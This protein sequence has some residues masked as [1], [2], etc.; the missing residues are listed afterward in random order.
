MHLNLDMV[1]ADAF[2][3]RNLLSDLVRRYEQ[4]GTPLP[5]IGYSY[6]RYL[7]EQAQALAN[8]KDEARAWWH[9]QLPSLPAA[10]ALPVHPDDDTE[11]TVTRRHH[12]LEQAAV[13]RL[14]EKARQ[15][16]LTPATV[17][18]TVFAEVIG[19]WSATDRFLLNL[20]VF[21]REPLHDDVD[22]LVGDFSSSVML[23]VDL[24]APMSFTERANALR[25]RL[26][27]ASSQAHYTGVE[28][29]RD[30]SKL[31]GE[32][33]IAPVVY[34]SALDLGELFSPDVRRCFGEPGWIISQGPQV[35][36]DAQVTEF[37]GGVLANWDARDS[38]FPA[39]M[40]DAMF[41]AY[42]GLIDR[43]LD[44]ESAWDEPVPPL[45][46]TAQ[47][48]ARDGVNS[49]TDTAEALV[50]PP[51]QRFF[52]IAAAEPDRTALLWGES[53]SMSYGELSTR[54]RGLARLLA[55][56]G[57]GPG[58]SV[59]ITLP[60]GRDQV[61]AVLAALATGATY[62][63]SGI[64]VPVA[65]REKVFG[66]AAAKF[67][68]TDHASAAEAGV[69][70]AVEPI[71]VSDATTA[72][73]I[74]AP[75]RVDPENVMY[76]IFTSGSTGDP[77]GVEV[78]HRAVANT[79]DAVNDHFA[80]TRD[81]RTIALSAVDFDL[82]AYDLFAFL[83]YGGSV[84]VPDEAQRRDAAAWAELI[85]RWDVTVVSCVP[86]L[87]D[88]LLIA[89]ADE[90]LGTALRL[91]MLG[92]DWVGVDLPARLRE[93]VPG[94]RFAGLGGMTEAAIHATVCEVDAVDPAWRAVPY[95]V[96]LAG[97]TCRVVDG[98]GRDCP[99]WVPGELW[100]GGA[101][102]A[103]GYR[104][105]PHRTAEK[106]V[107]HGGQRW[108]RT[109]DLVRY[110]PGAVLEFLG[111]TDHQ[112]KIRGHRIELGE[113][114]AA[115]TRHPQVSKAIATVV[116]NASRQLTAAVVAEPSTDAAALRSWLGEQLPGYLIPE[117]IAVVEAFPITYNGKID[118]K[119]I[120]EL[121]R[122]GSAEQRAAQPP[123][124]P[125]ETTLAQLWREVLGAEQVNRDDDFFTLG[126]D[127]LLATRLLRRLPESGLAGDLAALFTTP[128]LSGFAATLTSG[129]APHRTALAPDPD[130]RYDAF[131]LTDLQRGFWIGR[132]PAL[133]LGGV[134]S[135]FYLEFDGADIDL[136]RLEAALNRL[137]ERHDMLRA[138]ITED[139]T[140]RVLPEVPYYRIATVDA[141]HQPESTLHRLRHTLSHNLVDTARWPLFEVRA[142]RYVSGGSSRT[143][144]F[145]GLDSIVMDGRSIMVFYTE[146]DRLYRDLDAE[147][148]P[149][150]LA[151]RDYVLQ[152]RPD[153]QQVDA[154]Q[155]YWRQRVAELPP[156][157]R[158]PL[159]AQPAEIGTP[160]FHRLHHY[161]EPARW[162][163]IIDRCR[164]H[165]LTPSVVLLACYAEVLGA[166]SA[167]RELTVNLTLFDRRDVHD[168][169]G[170]VIGDF[171]SLLLIGHTAGEAEPF[172]DLARRL[173]EQQ[174]RGLAHR[175]T[176]GVWV[177]RELARQTGSAAA[178]L[179]VVFTSVLGTGDE[180]AS[181]DLSPGFPDLVYGV[182]Q[183]PQVWLDNKVATAGDGVTL[184]WDVVAALFPD[185]VAE[186]MFDSYVTLVDRLADADWTAP[187][188]AVLTPQHR[189]LRD[190]SQ[191]A[192]REREVT[193]AYAPVDGRAPDGE[194]ERIVAE[195]WRE[196][197]D[198]GQVSRTD[199]F[200]A[201]GGDSI[202]ATR[203]M[204]RLRSAGLAGAQL[205]RLFTNPV[206]HEFAATIT[207]GAAPGPPPL[208]TDEAQRHEPFGLTDIQ[209]AYW[210][211][212]SPDFA[213]GG[214]G[215]QLYNEY[216]WPGLDP[217]RI[218]TA[219]NTLIHRHEMLR[220]VVTED[221]MQRI[222]PEVPRWKIPVID[223]AG[224]FGAAMA[225]VR[226]DMCHGAL[227]AASW[228]LF[229]VRIVTDGE[230]SR[231][232]VVFDNIITDGLS[233]LTLFAEW[234][235][236][237][238]DP[239]AELAPIGL[240]FRDYV[241]GSAPD[242][243]KLD[244]ALSYW[245]DRMSELPPGPR[246][247]L[248][249]SPAQ[250]GQPRFTRR[251][252]RLD[253]ATWQA[254]TARARE[255]GLTPSVVLLACYSQVLGAFS[256]HRDLT[257]NLT[258][259]DRRDVHPDINRVVGDFTSLLLVAD[260]PAA[261]ESWLARATR[262]Q[263]Q[264]WRDL[265]H[266]E[267]SAVTV[268]RE[269]A[270]ENAAPAEPAPVVFTS[271]LGVDD[272]LARSVRWPDL[273]RSQT[274]QV[275]LDHQVIEL[276]DGLLLSWDAVDEL[277]PDG[278]VDALFDT[279]A[280]MLGWL[281]DGD[282]ALPAPEPL[283]EAQ[284]TARARV[285][286][287]DGPVPDG[288]LHGGF[289]AQADTHPDRVALR[290]S[291]G[292]QLG[293]GELALWSRRIARLLS[294]HGVAPG[295]AVAV[296]LPRGQAQVAA[297]LGVLTAGC[298]YVPI[299]VD[300]PPLRRDK[301]LARAG[302]RVLLTDGSVQAAGIDVVDI[303]DADGLVPAEAV[304]GSAAELA[305]VIFTSGSTGEPKGVEITHRSALNTLDDLRSRYEI[306][307]GDTV[308]ALSA[309]DFD[310]SVFDLFCLLGCGGSVVLITEAER[311]DP[312]SWLDLLHR[313]QVSIWN[314][315]PAMLDMLLTV[316]EGGRGMP[317]SLRLALLS[318]DWIGL[319]LPSRLAAHTVGRCRFVALGGATEAAIWS[320]AYD[321]DA[322]PEHWTSIPYGFPLRNQRFRVVDDAGRDRPGWVP[323][324]LWI[325][326]TG[327]AEGYRGEP[328]LTAAR[329]V[330]HDGV[331][332]YRTGD[333]GRY[334]PDGTL[335]FLGRRDNQV[336]IRGHRIELGEIEAAIAAHPAVAKVAAAVAD[337][338]G[339]A[340]LVAFVQAV[341]GAQA[342]LAGWLAD[343][344]PVYALPEIVPV[345]E[346]PLSGNGKLDRAALV[347]GLSAAAP[348]AADEPLRTDRE[349]AIAA[350]WGE[351]L[352]TTPVNRTDNFFTLGGDS[353]AATR[354]IR[355][356]EGTYGVSL[357]LRTFFTAPTIGDLD[358]AIAAQRT[359]S[360]VE[361]GTL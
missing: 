147:L 243:A 7:A 227:D 88:M 134:G 8:S 268:L 148:P 53:G 66:T 10:P 211:G 37:N 177:L 30:L 4:P 82:S 123:S 11:P 174:G 242:P 240:S 154:A 165:G 107:V 86:A 221:G 257:V 223:A 46:P 143:R 361:E 258:L 323:G 47:R 35:W 332:W 99:D 36:L 267:V 254:I 352:G 313:E 218:E 232:C 160:V 184:D 293:Y 230:T 346:F 126:G 215:A 21:A 23:D 181:L 131:P 59:G 80:I 246:L 282:W 185:G 205:A 324:E 64:D 19:A 253:T 155:R 245:R 349:R 41:D 168:D 61:I 248:R 180:D 319:D 60:K 120:G 109:G 195:L 315:V 213:L 285:N 175:A 151:F 26:R 55:D 350:L 100:V 39:G 226:E 43:L 31:S 206:L 260:R 76:V 312:Q 189:D 101:G 250:V 116:E 280:G 354:V 198:V 129:A 278:L 108:Y 142:A 127:S 114:E 196:L 228:P 343:R 48:A 119:A 73:P 182:T 112:V 244:Q 65:R 106:F 135:H 77:K 356:L 199:S 272:T 20:P 166:W 321:V 256:T 79:I 231:L 52:D 270:R 117:H 128:T 5:A 63:P 81:D 273:T 67:V 197:L 138:V 161:V 266:Q 331:R 96:P 269:L 140:Q 111:R 204:S 316:A 193:P 333:L 318:G 271:M 183:T 87:L 340:R 56:R 74:A 298:A 191:A 122:R 85:R 222:L 40:L 338:Q 16:G 357:S 292:S 345:D 306:G 310:L 3:L 347:A 34:T 283:P 91:V 25:T 38:A 214:I 229:D 237:Y 2:S 239:D 342:E 13:A 186:A 327:V 50:H 238:D 335:E 339:T 27:Q 124:G 224:D 317:A 320:N 105:D 94:C 351:Q 33:V 295:E 328:D 322:V 326:G 71:F 289:F 167:R 348:V 314:T 144:L 290:G 360:D 153:P 97:V 202:V 178:E 307:A 137:I 157:P 95:G 274:P 236:C 90:G 103:H 225:E 164:A 234:H 330:D 28:V 132:D 252:R 305:Y 83:G 12:W 309:A 173:Q 32:Q 284:R 22:D 170:L 300:Q 75:A 45:L 84:V 136:E 308:L 262:L 251:E 304:L 49:T 301:I 92:G 89:A 208:A 297:L 220:A 241:N 286:D 146:W 98:T 201:L 70:D 203:L 337:S 263:E 113:V 78:P 329:F 57:I 325:G 287:T 311:R 235:Q 336:K 162:R 255:H 291:D 9:D 216:E 54:A 207:T 51:H 303:A 150:G 219:L 188:P 281:A 125:V 110:L 102:V 264:V 296:C 358:E 18:A 192:A 176:S 277:F 156:G 141:A 210:L 14:A 159:A 249:I 69:P 209:S 169:I 276:P 288:V 279:Y 29:L 359:E 200:F 68:L 294:D 115:L 259:F 17:L 194:V 145:V 302:T 149:I 133:T 355:R 62:V 1:A 158:L 341:A 334:W 353:L 172:A 118:R 233:I 190:R 121:L 104:G 6:P 93:L 163:R 72:D 58:D 130:H 42:V 187:L 247:P 179:P 24:S 44:T 217:G 15:R 275:W 299:S 265:D 152:A 171:A 261:G 212:R 139:G 344:L